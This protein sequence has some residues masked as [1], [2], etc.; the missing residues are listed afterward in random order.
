MT[1]EIACN[2]FSKGLGMDIIED[3]WRKEHSGE[4]SEERMDIFECV[5]EGIFRTTPDGRPVLANPALAGIH[6][7]NS[8]EEYLDSVTDVS[9]QGYVNKSDRK[10][11]QF[12][13][14]K[15]GHVH[16]FQV[17]AYRNPGEIIW[18]SINIWTVERRAGDGTDEFYEGTIVDI[19]NQ[20]RL[21]KELK[22]RSRDLE[23]LQT[24][25]KVLLRCR[26][27]DVKQLGEK[28]VSN[29]RETVFPY[30]EKLKCSHLNSSQMA[31]LEMIEACLN[32]I[33]SPF[34]RNITSGFSNLTQ[35]E[36]RVACLIGEGKTT[37][38]IAQTLNVSESAID[39]HRYHIRKKF[40]LSNKSESLG[41]YLLSLKTEQY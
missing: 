21:E 41:S 6:G 1:F 31:N 2:I 4:S 37:K 36:I 38:E 10:H 30:L 9:L 32:E 28:V 40:N 29:V 25:L 33:V 5:T 27:E 14:K 24:A 22:A 8:T 26:N 20:K 3:S 35:K 17:P 12:L 34:V 18:V 7:Y 15:H 13:L 19:T 39:S 16:N 11:L 23:E